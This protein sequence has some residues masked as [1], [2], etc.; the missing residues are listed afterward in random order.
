MY[1]NQPPYLLILAGIGFYMASAI[2]Y[3]DSRTKVELEISAP[4]RED[5]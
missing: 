1:W 5:Q 4:A 2:V 3:P